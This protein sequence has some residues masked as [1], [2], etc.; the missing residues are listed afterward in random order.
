MHP[1]SRTQRSSASS[2]V[3][4]RSGSWL[5]FSGFFQGFIDF[6]QDGK[7]RLVTDVV[8]RDVQAGVARRVEIFDELDVLV[9]A[10]ADIE[11]EDIENLLDEGV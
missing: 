4:I 2:R 7:A 8:C 9:E 5:F 3:L 10:E 1:F 11:S 6:G